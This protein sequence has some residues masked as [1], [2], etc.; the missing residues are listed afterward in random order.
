MIIVIDGPA[1]S[2]KSS[3]AKAVARK[4]DIEYLDSGA[5]YRAITLLFLKA[6]QDLDAFFHLLNLTSVSFSFKKNTFCV[7]VDGT[8]VTSKLRSTPV[9]NH[10]SHVAALPR[11][12]TFVNNLMRNAVQQGSYIAEGRDLGTAVFEDADLKFYMS[13]DVEERAR[14]RHEELVAADDD[15]PLKE[16]RANIMDRDKKDAQRKADPLSKAPDAIELD[17]TGLR[18]EEQVQQICSMIDEQTDLTINKQ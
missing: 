7:Q 8:D 2:G 5:L 1:G 15:V 13:A 18:F 12:R 14:R 4:M 16:V 3:T 6:D 17:T 9:S 11:V 10:V